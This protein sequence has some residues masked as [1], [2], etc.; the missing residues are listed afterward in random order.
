M[1][2]SNTILYTTEEGLTK[3]ETTFDEDTV[4]QLL[5]QMVKAFERMKEGYSKIRNEALAH[6]FFINI[7]RRQVDN[8]IIPIKCRKLFG[9]RKFI[10]LSRKY[11][12]NT[13]G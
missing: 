11:V 7:Y 9:R 10:K 2:Q 8:V 3:I 6:A 13:E 1:N 12:N 4:W 5:D